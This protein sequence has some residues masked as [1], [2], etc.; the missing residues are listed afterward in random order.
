MFHGDKHIAAAQSIESH[1]TELFGDVLLTVQF[2]QWSKFC[3]GT[4]AENLILDYSTR[5]NGGLFLAFGFVF[6]LFLS[7]AQGK[8]WFSFLLRKNH[9]KPVLVAL[10]KFLFCFVIGR[11][12]V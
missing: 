8:L 3:S 9:G 7:D 2:C 4:E 11:L 10:S 1:Q 5:T 6:F 12:L